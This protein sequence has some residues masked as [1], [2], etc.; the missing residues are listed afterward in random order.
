MATGRR[1]GQVIE[2]AKGKYRLRWYVGRR[3]DG[4]H[5]YKQQ[6]FELSD[7]RA[8]N[9]KLG[10][11]VA[12]DKAG[13]YIAPT[14]ETVAEY[15]ERWLGTHAQK[16]SARTLADYRYT[17][18]AYV[19]P[20]VGTARLHALRTSD[21]QRMIG[22]LVEHGLAPRTIR[23]A[24]RILKSALEQAVRWQELGR[25]P[26]AGAELPA[27]EAKEMHALSAEDVGKLRKALAGTRFAL[28]VDVLLDT[29]MRPGEALGL[30]WADVDLD[31]AE[32]S[33][34]Q[35][36]SRRRGRKGEKSAWELGAPK[37]K[38]SRRT[39]PLNPA[40]VDGLRR[41]KAAQAAHVL[42]LKL[43]Q[44]DLDLVFAERLGGPLSLRNLTGRH[45]KPAL[46]A[47]ELPRTVRVYDLRHTCASLLLAAG[48]PITV[49]SQRLGHTS[50]AVTLG[51][52]AHVLPGQQKSATEKLGALIFGA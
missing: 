3:A 16:V 30:R 40:V 51:V 49:V 20:H 15:L 42:K 19:V 6:T 4:S 32:V 10:E 45:F 27:G 26:A 18:E 47:A 22:A 28:L 48:E 8:A 21:V 11:L 24:V 46:K 12:K 44:R 52:Y 5:E 34:R 7:R 9:T 17:L 1:T 29:G 38:R 2:V 36:L 23:M 31:A 25:N 14:L 33:V 50:A 43:Y 41:H 37:T 13:E 35:A 39:I